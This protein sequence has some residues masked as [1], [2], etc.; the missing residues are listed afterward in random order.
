MISKIHVKKSTIVIFL[1]P[2][3]FYAL[4]EIERWLRGETLKDRF[5]LF[6]QCRGGNV[7]I[8]QVLFN[9]SILIHKF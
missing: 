4:M 5:G 1:F 3:N 7:S 6:A 9:P 8:E 2:G